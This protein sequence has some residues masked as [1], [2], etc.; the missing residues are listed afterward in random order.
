MVGSAAFPLNLI[1]NTAGCVELEPPSNNQK[2]RLKDEEQPCGWP[3]K[4]VERTWVLDDSLGYGTKA[5]IACL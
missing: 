5:G 1:P 2:N 3:K 4:G